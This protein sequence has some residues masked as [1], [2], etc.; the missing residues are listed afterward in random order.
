MLFIPLSQSSI[1]GDKETEQSCL[2]LP[3]QSFKQHQFCKVIQ[4]CQSSYTFPPRL[5]T[6]YRTQSNQISKG[7]AAY[8]EQRV[9]KFSQQG[10]LALTWPLANRSHSDFV[11]VRGRRALLSFP[12]ILGRVVALVDRRFE[13]FPAHPELLQ[14]LHLN[15]EGGSS[16]LRTNTYLRM[17]MN[18]QLPIS[19]HHC[20]TN[21]EN[22]EDLSQ[23]SPVMT[24]AKTAA[25]RLLAASVGRGHHS[26]GV[27]KGLRRRCPSQ[28]WWQQQL[29]GTPCLRGQQ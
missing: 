21:L 1:E 10:L 16:H 24:S 3:D 27:P 26:P 2:L 18:Y 4:A 5:C 14:E 28:W 17:H 25:R 8:A 13:L 22:L 9:T 19:T 23:S 6:T 12:N 29:D 20:M 15:S 7:L 11:E